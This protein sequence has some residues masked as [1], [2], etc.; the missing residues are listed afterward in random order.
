MLQ[1]KLAEKRRDLVRQTDVDEMVDS[2]AG[3]VL[4]AL[5]G[6]PARVAG[7]DLVVRR[8]AEAI[9]FELR[10]EIANA[11][12]A[13]ADKTVSRRSAKRADGMTDLAEIDQHRARPVADV[14]E[15]VAV[16]QGAASPRWTDS[17][18]SR[19]RTAVQ[20][21]S[22]SYRQQRLSPHGWRTPRS[23]MP[24]SQSVVRV[25]LPSLPR[26]QYQRVRGLHGL[27]G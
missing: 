1:L 2:F 15:A 5:G 23:R 19:P 4:T 13:M 22:A 24:H 18:F 7:T 20:I 11:C 17:P 10:T 27:V 14:L 12:Q 9:L 6:W 25:L 8:R 26:P 16:G 3:I 21:T